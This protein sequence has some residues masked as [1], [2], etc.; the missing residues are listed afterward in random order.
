MCLRET[1]ASD[2]R[3]LGVFGG[4]PADI[5]P[6][7]AGGQVAHEASHDNQRP[8]GQSVHS[9][10]DFVP[11]LDGRKDQQKKREDSTS[12]RASQPARHAIACGIFPLLL[13]ILATV[14]SGNE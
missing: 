3:C 14:E 11:A 8:E 12:D 10:D 9:E 1:D 6:K 5:A 7:L 2:L 4:N 13:L